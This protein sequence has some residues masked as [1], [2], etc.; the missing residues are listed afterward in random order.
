MSTPKVRLQF[1]VNESEV[2]TNFSH[3]IGMLL[4][5]MQRLANDFTRAQTILQAA[6]AEKL[7]DPDNNKRVD[8]AY[9]VLVNLRT[10]LFEVDHRIE[11]IQG[12]ISGYQEAKADAAVAALKASLPPPPTINNDNQAAPRPHDLK[13]PRRNEVISNE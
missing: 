5:T 11:E 10:D 3:L 9:E 7:L 4:P 8:E 1:T 2:Y 13:V 12:M 6:D